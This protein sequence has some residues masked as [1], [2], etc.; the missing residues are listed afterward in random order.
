[1]GARFVTASETEEGRRWNESRVKALTGGDRISARF[2]RGDFF[3]FT[4]TFKLFITGNH[5]PHIRSLD[6]AMRRRLHLI[7]FA[8]TV[9]P[10]ERDPTLDERLKAEWPGILKWMIAGCLDWQAHGLCPPPAV[11]AATADYLAAEDAVAR[12]IDDQCATG[13][14]RTATNADLYRSW[15]EWC[16]TAGEYA[17]TQRR[18][19][20][21]LE[22]KGFER[23]W[24]GAG[25]AR[26]FRGI[27]LDPLK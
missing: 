23:G 25:G 9:P 27:A 14:E 1:L 7:P 18:L 5:R 2:M 20:D 16:A 22:S 12:W 11:T 21:I 3:E 26:G 24:R 10:E 15:T 17:G 8:V 19:L 13:P 4:P 6:E